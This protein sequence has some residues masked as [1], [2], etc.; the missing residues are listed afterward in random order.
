ML[1]YSSSKIA[2]L[3][4]YKKKIPHGTEKVE[5]HNL[6]SDGLLCAGEPDGGRYVIYIVMGCCVQVNQMVGDT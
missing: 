4:E 6:H 3:A 1:C 2:C 5:T